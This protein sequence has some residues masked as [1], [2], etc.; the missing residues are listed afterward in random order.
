MYLARC[1]LPKLLT[2]AFE[3][4]C[5]F[6]F[7]KP[8]SE[9][10]LARIACV[11][12]LKPSFLFH[13]VDLPLAV[14]FFFQQRAYK[15]LIADYS[16]SVEVLLDKF[17]SSF[18]F[19]SMDQ[20]WMRSPVAGSQMPLKILSDP[21]SLQEQFCLSQCHQRSFTLCLVPAVRSACNVCTE[22]SSLVV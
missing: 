4:D 8:Y 3:F 9:V 6:C 10:R 11:H 18:W 13:H 7:A 19:F 2:R 1:L 15:S 21:W 5:I 12:F 16:W 17:L 14:S 22:F 20:L